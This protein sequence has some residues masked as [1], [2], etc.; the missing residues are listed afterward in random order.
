M[1]ARLRRQHVGRECVE[2]GCMWGRVGSLGRPRLRE[3]KFKLLSG[4]EMSFFV[5]LS[6]LYLEAVGS[7]QSFYEEVR[8]C[9]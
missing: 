2:T 1:H 9:G 7:Q 4:C 6:C 8:F 3:G 5:G